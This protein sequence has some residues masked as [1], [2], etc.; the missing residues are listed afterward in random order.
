MQNQGLFNIENVVFRVS[1]LPEAGL[2]VEIASCFGVL[3]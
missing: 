3:E 2:P 1:V